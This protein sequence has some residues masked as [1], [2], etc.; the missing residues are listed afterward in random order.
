MAILDFCIYALLI[1]VFYLGSP[2]PQN[3]KLDIYKVC[4]ATRTARGQPQSDWIYT[5]AEDPETTSDLTDSEMSREEPLTLIITSGDL[6][7]LLITTNDRLS[8][9][10]KRHKRDQAERRLELKQ[11]EERREQEL[12]ILECERA[13]KR[14]DQMTE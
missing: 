4:T 1:L 2:A 6:L 12:R 11:A 8:L 9:E 5:P 3:I 7:Q 14:G 10:N 13:G